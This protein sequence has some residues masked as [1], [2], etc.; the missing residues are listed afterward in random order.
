MCLATWLESGT[1]D[2]PEET[3]SKYKEVVKHLR[4]NKSLRD[5]ASRCDVSLGTVQKVKRLA[6]A[7]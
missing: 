6:V 4:M 7:A 2:T 1:T 3:L 5:I